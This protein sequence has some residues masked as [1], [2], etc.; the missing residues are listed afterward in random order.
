MFS[1]DLSTR[2]CDGNLRQQAG[3]TGPSA[4]PHSRTAEPMT[5]S[6]DPAFQSAARNA[7]R[8]DQAAVVPFPG[9]ED[10]G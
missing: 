4:S 3:E 6:D 8:R 2:G 5:V 10:D 1:V 9:C 7:A